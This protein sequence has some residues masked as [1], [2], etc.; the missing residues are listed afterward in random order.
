MKHFTAVPSCRC[1]DGSGC[2]APRHLCGA[3]CGDCLHLSLRVLGNGEE[4]AVVNSTPS[5]IFT[6]SKTKSRASHSSF[7]HSVQF[8]DQTNV[9]L[10]CLLSI[11]ENF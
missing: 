10:Y 5:N 2:T 7:I 3:E 9:S 11:T 8:H 1:C 6:G 4:E